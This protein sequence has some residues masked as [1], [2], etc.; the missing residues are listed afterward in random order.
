MRLTG[1]SP[2]FLLITRILYD[3]LALI[4]NA[5]A[6]FGKSLTAWAF[7]LS[8]GIIR[9]KPAYFNSPVDFKG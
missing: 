4:G 1:E 3:M 7:L 8:W 2:S 6:D 5:L 9:T